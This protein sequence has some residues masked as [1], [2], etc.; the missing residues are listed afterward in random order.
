[1]SLSWNGQRSDMPLYRQSPQHVLFWI[2]VTF[3]IL[4]NKQWKNMCSI[5]NLH[6]LLHVITGAQWWHNFT[7]GSS[8]FLIR[9]NFPFI[10]QCKIFS[11]SI[12]CFFCLFS[13]T[14]RTPKTP[15]IKPSPPT[16]L[17]ACP[18]PSWPVTRPVWP[19]CCPA[20]SP[21]SS[22]LQP[23]LK[24][25]PTRRTRAKSRCRADR[26]ALYTWLWPFNKV[27]A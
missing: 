8:V 22:S 23:R 9:P 2:K 26:W 17:P 19:K 13:P 12:N 16:S 18:G 3:F 11:F 25:W 7:I 1:M 14:G 6:H 5:P 4:K 24:R 27:R 10:L 20:I 15:T 21:T